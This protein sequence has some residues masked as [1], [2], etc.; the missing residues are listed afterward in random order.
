MTATESPERTLAGTDGYVVES[1]EGDLGWV[2]EVWIDEANEPGALAVLTNDGRH[3]LLRSED[4]VAVDREYRWVVVQSDPELLELDPPR[5]VES[6]EGDEPGRLA[7]SW[8]TTG[9]VLRL[10]PRR[11]RRW[12]PAFLRRKSSSPGAEPKL[13]RAI[14]VLLSS[15]AFLVVFVATL[16]F[17]VARIVTG[18]AY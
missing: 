1:T 12:R 7:A 6:N 3:G 8:T 18:A 13:W 5:M 14:A 9:D 11:R 10:A 16:A 4:V 15:I 2:E 17:L